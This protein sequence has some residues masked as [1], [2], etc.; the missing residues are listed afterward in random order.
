MIKVALHRLFRYG[1]VSLAIQLPTIFI[2]DN[3]L[4]HR[5]EVDIYRTEIDGR[6]ALIITPKNSNGNNNNKNGKTK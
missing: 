4:K 2:N 3:E 1:T 5:S 6:D